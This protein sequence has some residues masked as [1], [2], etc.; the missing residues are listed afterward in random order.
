MILKSLPQSLTL[1]DNQKNT[2]SKKILATNIE[3]AS[4]I[5]NWMKNHLL[6]FS[7]KFQCEVYAL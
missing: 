3:F 2:L 7:L 6:S 1:Y 4:N 5:T